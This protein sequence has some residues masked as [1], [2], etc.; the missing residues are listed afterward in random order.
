MGI[1][2]YSGQR[3]IWAK[4]H[5]LVLD[6]MDS[7]T[8]VSLEPGLRACCHYQEPLAIWVDTPGCVALYWHVLALFGEAFEDCP[9]PLPLFLLTPSS[10]APS[11][12]NPTWIPEEGA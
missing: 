9:P 2:E 5:R 8:E 12:G 6:G 4:K 1:G 7:W 3:N 10:C 11:R